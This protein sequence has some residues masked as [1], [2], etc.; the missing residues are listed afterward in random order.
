VVTENP[1]WSP[2]VF[3]SVAGAAALGHCGG[4]KRGRSFGMPVYL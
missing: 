1:A 4:G 2:V 3:V